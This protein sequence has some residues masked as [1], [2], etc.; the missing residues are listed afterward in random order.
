VNR[1]ISVCLGVGLE[2][3]GRSLSPS[4]TN[5]Q[6]GFFDKGVAVDTDKT[7]QCKAQ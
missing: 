5:R 3:F 6:G 1:S 2:C 4:N 7:Q